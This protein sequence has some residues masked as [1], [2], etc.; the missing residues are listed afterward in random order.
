MKYNNGI[1]IIENNTTVILTTLDIYNASKKSKCRILYQI[2]VLKQA[3]WLNEYNWNI[4]L[5]IVE[6]IKL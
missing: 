4:G 1:L 2:M 5:S 6:N 3:M